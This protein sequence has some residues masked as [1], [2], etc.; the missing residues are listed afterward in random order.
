MCTMTKK[1]CIDCGASTGGLRCKPCANKESAE[2][3]RAAV[4][5]G[6][7][8]TGWPP[9]VPR[10]PET[11]AKIKAGMAVSPTQVARRKWFVC[12]KCG[13]KFRGGNPG[14]KHC[15]RDCAFTRRSLDKNTGY[16]TVKI[17]GQVKRVLEHRLI[18]EQHLGRPLLPEENVHHINGIKD[19]N[20]IENLELWSTSQPKGQRVIDKLEWARD[21]IALYG[22][23][24]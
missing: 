22:D 5:A 19:D 8:R 21:I 16:V 14:Q 6:G 7:K 4:I 15:S 13:K 9:G 11:I 20:R 2:R 3:R 10:T 17:P 24:A 23:V 1:E 18:M 12:A